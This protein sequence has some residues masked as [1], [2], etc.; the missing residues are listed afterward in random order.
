M[1]SGLC[2]LPKPSQF[3]CGR[4][5]INM[6]QLCTFERGTIVI[7]FCLKLRVR[8]SHFRKFP[9]T[10]RQGPQWPSGWWLSFIARKYY[11]SR[12]AR[13]QQNVGVWKGMQLLAPLNDRQVWFLNKTNLFFIAPVRNISHVRFRRAAANGMFCCF[14]SLSASF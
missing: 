4:R 8:I 6:S 9:N 5:L 14:V 12:E 10:K 2:C 1:H 13:G 3:Y 11:G 7:Y